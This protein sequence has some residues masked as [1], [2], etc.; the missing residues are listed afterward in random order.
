MRNF[1]ICILDQIYLERSSVGSDVDEIN[2]TREEIKE[3]YH[4]SALVGKT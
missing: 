1:I 3:V 2:V 4:Y